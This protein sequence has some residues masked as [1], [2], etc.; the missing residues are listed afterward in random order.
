MQIEV[1]Y[2]RLICLGLTRNCQSHG[3]LWVR[4]ISVDK[5]PKWSML[6]K[7]TSVLVYR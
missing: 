6:F 1:E 3:M 5:S 2:E 7:Y 4:S